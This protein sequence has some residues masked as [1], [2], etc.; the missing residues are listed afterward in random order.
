[1]S[2]IRK[3][4]GQSLLLWF[5]RNR[6][7][8]KKS[9]TALLLI[10]GL[11][12]YFLSGLQEKL[13]LDFFVEHLERMQNFARAHPIKSGFLYLAFL[14]LVTAF[15]VPA[16]AVVTVTSGAVFP[17]WQA[18]IYSSLGPTLGGLLPYW[19]AR[20]TFRDSFS[21]I[22]GTRA[23]S[24]E[25]AFRENALLYMMVL[26]LLPVMPVWLVNIIAGLLNVRLKTYVIGTAIGGLPCTLVWVILGDGIGQTLKDGQSI[27]PSALLEPKIVAAL[28]GLSLLALGAAFFR[29]FR[30]RRNG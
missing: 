19:A 26:R 28:T 18:G 27:T 20:Y 7:W 22:A 16:V 9:A 11:A 4:A 1:M 17:I 13:T 6:G 3:S 10:S 14:I 12:A 25:G 8:L 21:R 5:Y 15:N 29:H 23:Q 24:L 2:E 30:G